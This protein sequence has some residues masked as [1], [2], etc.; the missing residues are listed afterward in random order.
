M[1]RVILST[2]F[3]VILMASCKDNA[4]TADPAPTPPVVE[5][6][7]PPA[8]PE[9]RTTTNQSSTT[10]TTTTTTKAE[11]DPDGT[12]V[13]IGRDGVDFSTKKGDDRVNVSTTT[14]EVQIKTK[15]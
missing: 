5:D 1:K 2:A 7:A 6:P 10:T 11:E 14:K 8:R 9:P 15:N 12:S 4:P 3:A 13:S